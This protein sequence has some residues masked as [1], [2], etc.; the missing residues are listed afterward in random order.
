LFYL[1]VNTM[2]CPVLRLTYNKPTAVKIRD[3]GDACRWLT[4]DKTTNNQLENWIWI[5]FPNYIRYA[6]RFRR[7]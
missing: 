2:R 1:S 7:K 4:S 3:I 6:L 5:N